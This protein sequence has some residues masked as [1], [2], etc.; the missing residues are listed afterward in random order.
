[1]GT[2]RKITER[3]FSQILLLAVILLLSLIGPN[4][5]ALAPAFEDSQSGDF[6]LRLVDVGITGQGGIGCLLEQSA[7]AALF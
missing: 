7:L 5:V 3:L 1:M 2:D 6:A 4:D